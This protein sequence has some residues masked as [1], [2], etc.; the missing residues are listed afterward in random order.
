MLSRLF[1]IFSEDDN[2]A[3]CMAKVFSG[4]TFVGFHFYVGYLMYTGHPPT[5]SEY[6]NASLQ[7]LAGSGIIIAGKQIT[8][9]TV[10]DTPPVTPAQ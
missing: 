6:A 4:I 5:L 1:E 2:K 7:V 10:P 3:L 8:Q 9:K